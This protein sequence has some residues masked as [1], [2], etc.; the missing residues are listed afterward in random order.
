VAVQDALRDLV[1]G[2]NPTFNKIFNATGYFC[3]IK[4]NPTVINF[5][6]S[7]LQYFTKKSQTVTVNH[8]NGSRRR[9]IAI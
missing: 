1:L 2:K 7:S 4:I 6:L 9:L 5:V 3:T 8:E